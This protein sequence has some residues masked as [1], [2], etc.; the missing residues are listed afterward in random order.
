M[1]TGELGNWGAGSCLRQ[2]L[3][4]IHHVS[5]IERLFDC[6]HDVQ[7][8][9][10]LRDQVFELAHADAVLARAGSA[11]RQRAAHHSLI[12]AMRLGQLLL[13]LGVEDVDQVKIAVPGMADE[14]NRDRGPLLSALVSLM[15]S[16]SAEIGT[17]TSVVQPFEPGRRASA[18]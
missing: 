16:A 8:R 10:V 2:E 11:E 14:R 1:E 5:R 9:A 13:V 7:R 6:A 18:A 17:H 15:H 12:E 3:A 4:G